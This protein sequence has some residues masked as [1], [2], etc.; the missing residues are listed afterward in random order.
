L[1]ILGNNIPFSVIKTTS[2][3]ISY[4]YGD[5]NNRIMVSYV[6]IGLYLA[7]EHIP[8][9]QKELCYY[10]SAQDGATIKREERWVLGL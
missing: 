8:G 7:I 4:G 9:I 5:S 2:P 1:N 6:Y 3:F 10:L